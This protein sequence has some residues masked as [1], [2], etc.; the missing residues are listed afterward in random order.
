MHKSDE[1]RQKYKGKRLRGML[2]IIPLQSPT[3][4]QRQIYISKKK[5]TT[6]KIPIAFMATVRPFLFVYLFSDHPFFFL[7]S[8]FVIVVCVG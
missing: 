7:T 3:K 8:G 6:T 1:I 5:N 2:L 4:T